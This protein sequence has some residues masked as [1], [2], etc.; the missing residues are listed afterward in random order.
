[1]IPRTAGSILSEASLRDLLMCSEYYDF[2]GSTPE[3]WWAPL[4]QQLIVHPIEQPQ[5]SINRLT[6]SDHPF[7][8]AS[9]QLL[10]EIDKKKRIFKTHFARH[11]FHNALMN[12]F[13][14][15]YRSIEWYKSEPVLG[16]TRLRTRLSKTPI[17]LAIQGAVA[18]PAPYQKGAKDR[19]TI[20]KVSEA[21]SPLQAARDPLLLLAAS[22]SKT[23][24]HSVVRKSD[25]HPDSCLYYIGMHAN[26]V[27]FP[28][29]P[30][31]FKLYA[32]RINFESLNEDKLNVLHGRLQTYEQH[33][34]FPSWPCPVTRCKYG[35]RCNAF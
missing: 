3:K 32:N 11:Q 15:I 25:L 22:A 16:P 19:Y 7:F 35:K 29:N 14:N 33:G 6:Q 31:Q 23:L 27:E 30:L 5:I 12:Q 17:E 13:E 9:K 28:K 20:I 8:M 21:T 10:T 34:S 18:V 4:L 26:H 2:G 1:M 24:L